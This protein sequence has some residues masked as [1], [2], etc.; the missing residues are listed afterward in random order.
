MTFTARA[1]TNS[2]DVN[3]RKN[4][5]KQEWSP[6]TYYTFITKKILFSTHP[7]HTC[8]CISLDITM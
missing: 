3:Q 5:G 7:Q 6:P 1:T 4:E 8:I 2:E